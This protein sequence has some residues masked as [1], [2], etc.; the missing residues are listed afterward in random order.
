MKEELNSPIR[1]SSRLLAGV[2]IPCN[3]DH[4]APDAW[5]QVERLDRTDSR[6]ASYWRITIDLP[7]TDEHSKWT[8]IDESLAGWG[9]TPEMLASALSFLTACA[10]GRAYA[11]SQGTS[12]H[13]TD[14]NGGLWGDRV[15]AW[16]EQHSDE[17]AC[18][19]HDIRTS[20]GQ[21]S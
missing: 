1:I 14:G 2:P 17:L 19:E 4:S 7:A 8:D 10:E 3:H 5:V 9:D 18:L 20:L 6:G 12:Y 13:G 16:A 11:T 15:G 21:S